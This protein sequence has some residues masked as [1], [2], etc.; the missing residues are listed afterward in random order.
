MFIYLILCTILTVLCFF[1][2]TVWKLR[3]KTIYASPIFF[4]IF[5]SLICYFSTKAEYLNS[6]KSIIGIANYDML[7]NT[8]HYNYVEKY[9]NKYFAFDSIVSSIFFILFGIL[10]L[11]IPDYKK[12]IID[13]SDN[14][15]KMNIDLGRTSIENRKLSEKN[16]ELINNLADSDSDYESDHGSDSDSK[17]E[18]ES[19]SDSKSETDSDHV[20]DS[21]SI[22][23]HDPDIDPDSKDIINNTKLVNELRFLS[24]KLLDSL[25][26]YDNVIKN[27]D[28]LN[29]TNIKKQT[30]NHCKNYKNEILK[31]FNNRLQKFP[32]RND[33]S[34]AIKSIRKEIT[35]IMF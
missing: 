20:P 24:N 15:Y 3:P 32:K 34:H 9:F 28:I 27:A 16:A 14:L 29:K 1:T 18:S 17:S 19:D 33:V 7:S 4:V 5:T 12:K 31:V 25:D 23:D 21:D 6:I 2:S 11:D 22:N 26:N 30:N 10:Y 13:L 35:D 8:E